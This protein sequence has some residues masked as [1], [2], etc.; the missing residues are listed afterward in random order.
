MNIAVLALQG[1]FVEHRQML[2]GLGAETFEIRQTD[3]WNKPKDALIIPGGESTVM[4]NQ[5]AKP[6]SKDYPFSE[7]APDLSSCR[8]NSK[9]PVRLTH[10]SQQ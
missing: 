10:V 4:L 5:F 1:A 3:D 2:R 7:P 8:N 9:T 6:S